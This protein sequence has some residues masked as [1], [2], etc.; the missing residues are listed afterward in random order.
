M[1]QRGIIF[2]IAAMNPQKLKQGANMTNSPIETK[3]VGPVKATIWEN[4]N[5][6]NQIYHTA[7]IVRTYRDEEGNWKETNQFF[8]DHLP[9]V[10][11]ASNQAFA[12]IHERLEQL[13]SERAAAKSNGGDDS[14]KSAPASSK[15]QKQSHADKVTADRAGKGASKG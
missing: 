3:R 1:S 12:F 9:L 11:L 15:G 7:I 10:Q 8:T 2:Q 13:R 14:E 4:T 6:K 5:D